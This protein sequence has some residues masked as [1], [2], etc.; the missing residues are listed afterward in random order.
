MRAT[1][2]RDIGSY[3]CARTGYANPHAP[4]SV[5]RVTYTYD[6]NGN[7]TFDGTYTYTWDYQ[8]RLTAVGNGSATSTYAYDHVGN[9]VKVTTASSTTVFPNR[10]YN[11]TTSGTAATVKSVFAGS[12][13]VATAESNSSATSTI[14]FDA[15]VASSTTGFVSGSASKTWTHTVGTGN[16]RMLLLFAD[17]WQ[18]V[19]GAG[20]ITSA[21]YNGIALTKATSTRFGTMATEI[22]YL[23][24]PANAI[25]QTYAETGYA[26]PTPPIT[27]S[28]QSAIVP[29]DYT[30]GQCN[31]I[32]TPSI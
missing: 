29:L 16:N 11:T 23:A 21:S 9:R 31:R 15:A 32:I 27:T 6:N 18:D 12:E 5:N 1:S 7:L 19:G 8:N 3:S 4:T 25:S 28:P 14:A 26:N 30:W 20:T 10:F 2:A 13:L 22:W 17:I 24:A